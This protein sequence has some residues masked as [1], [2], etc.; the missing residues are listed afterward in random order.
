MQ[1]NR[2]RLQRVKT[3]GASDFAC[4]MT[5]AAKCHARAVC[6]V[7]SLTHFKHAPCVTCHG[8]RGMEFRQD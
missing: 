2:N 3:L 4:D 6:A 1:Q 7:F 5:F 8:A